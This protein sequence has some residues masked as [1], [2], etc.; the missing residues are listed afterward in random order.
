MFLLSDLRR[1]ENDNIY[2]I[3]RK[4][5]NVCKFCFVRLCTYIY[6]YRD[7][8]HVNYELQLIANLYGKL[9]RS[10]LIAHIHNRSM[11]ASENASKGRAHLSIS[12]SIFR[13]FLVVLYES[14]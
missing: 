7:L 9:R 13:R 8:A 10:K 4:H 12:P 2:S 5:Q 6:I 1:G 14:H 3:A 11:E